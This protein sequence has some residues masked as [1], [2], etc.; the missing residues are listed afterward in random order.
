MLLNRKKT[1]SQPLTCTL[2]SPTGDAA[3]AIQCA[4]SAFYPI[5][6]N[7]INHKSMELKPLEEKI[8]V[9][10]IYSFMIK[11]SMHKLFVDFYMQCDINRKS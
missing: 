6:M 8:S 10:P 4:S 1:A 3:A 11:F 9:I 7:G 2:K 5:F